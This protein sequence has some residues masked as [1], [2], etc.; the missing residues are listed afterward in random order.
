MQLP[1]LISAVR[2]RWFVA[3]ALRT[4]GVSMAVAAVPLLGSGKVDY[5]GVDQ[6]AT[7]LA[8]AS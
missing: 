4:A 2:R 7:G 8:R 1:T 6:L 5:A 3:V